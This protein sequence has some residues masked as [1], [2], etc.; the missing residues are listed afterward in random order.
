MNRMS[1]RRRL[2]SVPTRSPGFLER[3]PGARADVDAQLARDQL[4][5]RRLAESRRSEEE[6]VV[7]R[8]A[9]R[10]RRVDGDPEA[11]LHLLLADE[12]RE[13]LRPKR[14]L[15]DGLLGKHFRRRDLGS[16]HRYTLR[17]GRGREGER[18]GRALSVGIY[19]EERPNYVVTVNLLSFR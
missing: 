19:P 13:P 6:R 4:G 15:D 11:V 2:V 12:L 16:G 17:A 5:Q 3:G 9:S 8:L 1:P 18:I 7:E 10:D 14:Q